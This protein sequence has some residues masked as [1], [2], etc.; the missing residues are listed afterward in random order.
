MYKAPVDVISS[1]WKVCT[2]A[3]H[4]L[5]SV[6]QAIEDEMSQVTGSDLIELWVGQGKADLCVFPRL[7]HG[8][9]LVP[10]VS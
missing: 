4:P 7:V 2:V 5:G 6:E 1:T 10:K 9:K 8:A 3:K